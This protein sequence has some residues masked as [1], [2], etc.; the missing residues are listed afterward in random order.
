MQDALP[1]RSRRGHRVVA[2]LAAVAAVMLVITGCTIAREAER[3]LNADLRMDCPVAADESVDATVRIGWQTIANGDLI[4]QDLGLLETCLPNATIQWLQ[5]KGGDDVVQAFG[6][7]AI[8]L[9]ISGSSAGVKAMSPPLS[10]PVQAVWIGDVIGAAEALV[11]NDPEITTVEDL[12]G[13]TVAVTFGATTHYSL[14]SVLRDAGIEDDVTVIN[15]S[16]DVLPAAWGRGE[17]DAAWTWEPTLGEIVRA[18]G[19]VIMTSAESAE[20]GYFTF[21]VISAR[22]DFVEQEPEFMQTWTALQDWAVGYIREDPDRAAESMS[23]LLGQDPAIVR[24]Q[25]E[26]YVYLDARELAGADYFGGGMGEQLRSTATFLAE[27]Q[28][29][30]AADT[31]DHYNRAVYADAVLKVAGS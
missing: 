23:V 9:G 24:E 7:A 1:G 30:D 28:L 20:L 4:I 17:V 10:L 12:A 15:L 21:D 3:R 31:L 26:G 11:S 19:Q 16:N 18:G 5:F 8:D 27:V 6:S 2:M 22:T 25:M 14:L 13:A 29:V